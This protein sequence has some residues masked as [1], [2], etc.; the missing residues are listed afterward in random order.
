MPPRFPH[1]LM[2][3]PTKMNKSELAV[4]AVLG[5]S[6]SAGFYQMGSS[7]MQVYRSSGSGDVDKNKIAACPMNWGK[8][9]S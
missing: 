4:L 8:D 9:K 6:V 2:K 7:A 1:R 3:P 5:A